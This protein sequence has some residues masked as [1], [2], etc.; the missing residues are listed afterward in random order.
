MK[1]IFVRGFTLIELLVVIAIIGILSSIILV[2]L[3]SARTKGNDAKVKEQLNA[4]RTAVEMY[5]NDNNGSYVASSFTPANAA[6]TGLMFTNASTTAGLTGNI[7]A[8]PTST[9]LSCQAT[10]AA[11]GVSASLSSGGHWC[12]DSSGA[13]KYEASALP[14]G[15]T[16]CP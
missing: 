6:C 13:S 12:V 10:T 4:V 5:A 8:W 14:S 9:V 3:S 7:G 16:V 11:W 1:K 2:S 15:T